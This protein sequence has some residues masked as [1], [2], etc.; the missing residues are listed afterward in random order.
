MTKSGTKPKNSLSKLASANADKT[1]NVKKD[2]A[3]AEKSAGQRPYDGMEN[4]FYENMQLLGRSC[5]LES[6]GLHLSN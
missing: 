2:K 4:V 3:T 5:R 6:I 1:K